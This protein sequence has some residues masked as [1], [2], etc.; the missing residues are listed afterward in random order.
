MPRPTARLARPPAALAAAFALTACFHIDTRLHYDQAGNV[1]ET[2]AV[3]PVGATANSRPLPCQRLQGVLDAFPGILETQGQRCILRFAPRPAAAPSLGWQPQA[4]PDGNLLVVPGAPAALDLAGGSE[5]FIARQS[6]QPDLA[7]TAI[8]LLPA[9]LYGTSR[10][11]AALYRQCARR[12]RAA[13][14]GNPAAARHAAAAARDA[15]ETATVSITVT[16]DR[17]APGI[18]PCPGLAGGA[19]SGSA[20]VLLDA[21]AN[22]DICW[23]VLAPAPAATTGGTPR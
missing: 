21:L 17:H 4:M 5:A 2:I 3:A 11:P 18:E 7:C 1:A 22:R 8:L 6:G 9:A 12:L 16:R 10:D 15:L 20:R 14:A 19:W 23:R 13:V